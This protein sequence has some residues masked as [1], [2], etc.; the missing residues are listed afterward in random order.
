MSIATYLASRQARRQFAERRRGYDHAAG[1]LLRGDT[2]ADLCAE[3]A[4]PRTAFDVGV[5]GATHKWLRIFPSV[6]VWGDAR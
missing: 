6:N 4:E 2:V 1:R 3:Q 5:A